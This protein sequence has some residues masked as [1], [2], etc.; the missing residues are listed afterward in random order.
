MVENKYEIYICVDWKISYQSDF[1]KEII[2]DFHENKIPID[3]EALGLLSI[4]R[5]VPNAKFTQIYGYISTL[6][7]FP[8]L[9]F[10]RYSKLK[11][12]NIFIGMKPISG[13]VDKIKTYEFRP[14]IDGYIYEEKDPYSRW[15]YENGW[16]EFEEY[17]VLLEKAEDLIRRE[18]LT[19]KIK[20]E[21]DLIETYYDIV[22]PIDTRNMITATYKITIDLYVAVN[23]KIKELIEK[24]GDDNVLNIIKK[25]IK[26]KVINHFGDEDKIYLTHDDV[27][28]IE[29]NL[30]KKGG[31]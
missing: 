9:I 4:H 2:K 27:R 3:I 25:H 30:L 5:I 19:Y 29:S 21:E 16:I 31:K 13:P 20:S 22:E 18:H 6:D 24:Y 28:I 15:A 26:Y 1:I 11:G 7:N 23:K 14:Y 12:K 8:W 17:D 10:T